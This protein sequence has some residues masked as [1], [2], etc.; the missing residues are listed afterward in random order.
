MKHL[1]ADQPLLERLGGILEPVE[2]RDPNGKVLGLYTPA[3]PDEK[4]A[5][6][7][8]TDYFDLAEAERTLTEPTQGSSLQDVW[9]RIRAVESQG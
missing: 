3:L 7:R 4:E 6:A 5:N 2:I 8:A 1:T 9:Q